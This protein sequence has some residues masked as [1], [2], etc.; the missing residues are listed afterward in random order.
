[1][2]EGNEASMRMLAPKRVDC[3]IPHRLEKRMKPE[4][5]TPKRTI[6]AGGWLG[7][8]RSIS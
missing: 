3:E 2:G 5:Q 4:L 6:P 7:L 8:L 1:V